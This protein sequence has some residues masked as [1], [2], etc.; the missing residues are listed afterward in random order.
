MTLF[1]IADMIGIVTFAYA[2]LLVGIERK[3]DLLGVVILALLTALGGGLIRDVLAA[4]IPYTLAHTLP[5]AT[6]FVT[7]AAVLLFKLYSFKN[8]ENTHLFIISDAVGLSAFSVAGA[9]VGLDAGL[10]GFGVVLVGFVTAVG[11][12]IIRDVLINRVPLL[13]RKDFYGTVAIIVAI[14]VYLLDLAGLKNEI[15]LGAI[16]VLGVVIRLLAYFRGWKL[17]SVV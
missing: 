10:N 3:L 6:V 4:R 15:M 11:G 1:V 2:G 7:V 9:I 8:I 5:A 16:F 14:L 17:P 12:G 13:L